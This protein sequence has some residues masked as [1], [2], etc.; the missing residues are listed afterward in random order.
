VYE[1]PLAKKSTAVQ[2]KEHNDEK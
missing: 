1:G 2:R